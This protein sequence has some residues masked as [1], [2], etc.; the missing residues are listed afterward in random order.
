MHHRNPPQRVGPLGRQHPLLV[1]LPGR[2][3]EY[4]CDRNRLAVTAG[5]GPQQPGYK[6][7][8]IRCGISR[9]HDVLHIIADA[10]IIRFFQDRQCP[11]R[12]DQL[13]ADIT[14]QTQNRIKMEDRCVI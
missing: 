11:A 5:A 10:L 1:P 14:R 6:R 9:L 3:P 2:R 13:Q 8:I 12:I 7:R 4:F